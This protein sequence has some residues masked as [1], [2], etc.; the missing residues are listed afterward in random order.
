MS[1]DTLLVVISICGIGTVIVLLTALLIVRVMRLSVFGIARLVLNSLT[2]PKEE[3]TVLDARP[4]SARPS[5]R[6]LRSR[7]R[8]LD[9]DAAV[10]RQ[11]GDPAVRTTPTTPAAPPPPINAPAEGQT[12]EYS[13]P[14]ALRDRRRRRRTDDDDDGILDNLLGGQDDGLF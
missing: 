7:A 11:G 8:A 1:S 2:E 5:S 13:P 4:Q 10:A 12:V 6:D 9:F 3:E 14:P